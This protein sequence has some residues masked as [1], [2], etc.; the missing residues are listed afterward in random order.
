MSMYCQFRFAEV[1]NIDKIKF[2]Y[3]DKAFVLNISFYFTIKISVE[4]ANHH[5]QSQVNEQADGCF[6]RRC[7]L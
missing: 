5:D 7:E 2:N 6:T 3:A 4:N 1:W